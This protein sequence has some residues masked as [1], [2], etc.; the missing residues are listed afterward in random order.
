MSTMNSN[1]VTMMP[2]NTRRGL[3]PIQNNKLSAN[4]KATALTQSTNTLQTKNS[5]NNN[6]NNNLKKNRPLVS[7]TE[8]ENINL[9]NKPTKSV[10]TSSAF[11]LPAIKSRIP[12]PSIKINTR[13]A[14]T[15]QLA[16]S[17]DKNLIRFSSFIRPI[18]VENIDL[19][20]RDNVQLTPEYIDDIYMYL[21]HLEEKLKIK[22]TDFLQK[23]ENFNERMR[24][25]LVDWIAAVHHKFKLLPE[26]LYLTI[27]IM[28]RFLEKV[29]VSKVKVQLVGLTS[30][31]IACKYEEIYPPELNDFI[32]ICDAYTKD[33]ILKMEQTILK[34]LDF[35]LSYPLP[36]HFLRRY[37]KAAHADQ[38]MHTLAKYLM[39]LGLIDYECSSWKPSL[40]AATSLYLTCQILDDG[41]NYGQNSNGDTKWTK[42]LQFY[43]KYKESELQSNV[44]T[45]CKLIINAKDSKLQT[46]YRK[47]SSL[48]LMNISECPKLM[49][50]YVFEM[51]LKGL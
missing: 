7:I 47:Y 3:R 19:N 16:Q 51:A 46:I 32:V 45:L 48:K 24:S 17:K 35:N 18:G 9:D 31:F 8:N 38:Q 27:A 2:A 40:L 15:K 23:Q 43:T 37:S 44:S 11:P 30:F 41:H 29:N 36:L 20:D 21:N 39:E 42:T 6:N 28:D 26:T 33:E 1:R 25:R 13:S 14:T 10:K 49:C 34:T 5:T 4:L 12:R 22:S 50:D